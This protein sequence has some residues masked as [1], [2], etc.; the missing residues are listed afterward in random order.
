M[1]C[2]NEMKLARAALTLI[3]R[4]DLKGAEVGGYVNVKKWLESIVQDNEQAL[5][6]HRKD[7]TPGQKS[8][9]EFIEDMRK[10]HTKHKHTH[11]HD[12]PDISTISIPQDK[13]SGD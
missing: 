8:R 6:L 3:E 1:C 10:Q 11:A 2:E 5:E 4:A 13:T 12:N 9:E 7:K